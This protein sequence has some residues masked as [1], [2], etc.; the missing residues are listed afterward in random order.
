MGSRQVLTDLNSSGTLEG[1]NGKPIRVP[2]ADGAREAWKVLLFACVCRI[3]SHWG[4][5][6]KTEGLGVLP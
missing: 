1:H 5:I 3:W 6:N 4:K 2:S